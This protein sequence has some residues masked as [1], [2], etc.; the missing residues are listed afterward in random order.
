MWEEGWTDPLQVVSSI[1][2]IVIFGLL[3]KWF[4]FGGFSDLLDNLLFKALDKIPSPPPMTASEE[5]RMHQ[6]MARE[7][8]KPDPSWAKFAAIAMGICITIPILYTLVSTDWA[9]WY[10]ERKY[11][12]WFILVF[13]A[14][15]VISSIGA[16]IDKKGKRVSVPVFLLI[17][18]AVFFAVYQ[19]IP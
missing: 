15:M 6:R 17:V 7:M 4:F 18:G 14:F 8:D 12:L 16:W 5:I 2:S 19:L 13:I 9:A 1:L 11:F 3:I 10:E